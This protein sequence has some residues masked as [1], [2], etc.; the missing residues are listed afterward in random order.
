MRI[1]GLSYDQRKKNEVISFVRSGLQDPSF[2][3][4][5]DYVS[6]GVPVPDDDE[7]VMYVWLDASNYITASVTETPK[8]PRSGLRNIGKM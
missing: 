8:R 7:H 5:K 1:A 2:S 6:W 4:M 3:R